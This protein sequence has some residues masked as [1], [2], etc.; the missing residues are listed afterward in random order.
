MST[1]TSTTTT[2]TPSNP[3]LFLNPQIPPSPASKLQWRPLHPTFGAEVS[4]ID[5]TSLPLSDQVISEIEAGIGKYGVVVFR[6]TGLSDPDFVGLGER[7]GEVGEGSSGR[8][9]T[10]KMGDPSNLYNDGSIVMPGELRWFLAK[11]T[12]LFH[13]DGVSPLI[14]TGRKGGC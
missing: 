6:N 7:L 3:R 8:F 11:E 1:F 14:L 2:E 12:A 5:F 4:G 9:P 10:P 13:S